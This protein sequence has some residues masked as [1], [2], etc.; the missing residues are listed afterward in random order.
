MRLGR[1]KYE[2][3]A[4]VVERVRRQ[5]YP[6]VA[7][8]RPP[9]VLRCYI[10][11]MDLIAQEHSVVSWTVMTLVAVLAAVIGKTGVGVLRAYYILRVRAGE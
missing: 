5:G 7:K 10:W 2:T 3:G 6:S 8:D 11:R 9:P 4:R 1:G